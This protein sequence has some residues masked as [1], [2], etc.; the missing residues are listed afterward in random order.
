MAWF[1]HSTTL[2]CYGV[3]GVVSYR[4]TL[5]SAT[6][7]VNSSDVNSPPLAERKALNFHPVS[8]ST[9]AWYCLIASTAQSLVANTLTH[10][11]RLTSSTSRMKYRLQLGIM[12]DMGPHISPW[13]NP[14]TSSTLYFDCQGNGALLCFPI[15]QPVHNCSN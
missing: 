4:L 7:L 10:M 2:F 11:N 13:T 3:Y 1:L 8:A 12:S 15:T 6:C 14:R 5:C 9:T